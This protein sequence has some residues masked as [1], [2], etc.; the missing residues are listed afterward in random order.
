MYCSVSYCTV[1]YRIAGA[2]NEKIFLKERLEMLRM[3]KLALFDRLDDV[4][5]K[6][7]ET[8]VNQN[9]HQDGRLE[10]IKNRVSTDKFPDS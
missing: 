3:Q 10:N 5:T 2:A 7:F 8:M 4:E 1:L 6:V 9:N